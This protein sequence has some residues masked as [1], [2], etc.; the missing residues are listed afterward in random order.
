[1]EL[2]ATLK[3]LSAVQGS[4]VESQTAIIFDYEA[5]WASELDSHPSEDVNYLDV[6]RAFHRE[7]FL[8]GITADIV[9]PGAD[10]SGYKLILVCTLYSVSD[11]SAAN[12]A[13]AAENGATVLIS[14]FSG[15]VDQDDAVRL[16]GYPGAFREL[17]GINAE[18]FHPLPEHGTVELD[19][20]WTCRV[21][22]EDLRLAGAEAV[23]SFT[24]YP[25]AGQPAL[26]RRPVGSGTAWY[27]ATFPDTAGIASLVDSLIAESGVAAPVIATPGVELTRRRGA[28]GASYLFAINHTDADANVA[29]SGRELVTGVQFS[30]TV[31]AGAVAVVE[32]GTKSRA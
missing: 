1:M 32:E 2:G 26:T 4:L 18:E 24:E 17:L 11:A 22:S 15:I 23:A 14:Y 6:L 5:W 25:L 27:L 30:G 8:R 31:R 21:W 10:L 19:N 16:G 3:A 13:A 7:L 29:A 12:I 9:H 28:D 20:G